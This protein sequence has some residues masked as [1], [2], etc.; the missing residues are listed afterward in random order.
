MA[1]YFS[2]CIPQFNRTSFLKQALLSFADQSFRDFEFCISDG[3]STDGRVD[4]LD[5]FLG[6]LGLPYRLA[7][8]DRNYRYDANLRRAIGLS[9]G[10]YLL[11]M[12]NDDAL[13]DRDCLQYLH[14]RLEAC[15]GAAVAITNFVELPDR[16]LFRRMTQTGSMGS[17]PAV[18][19]SVFRHHAFVSG[20]VFDG[21]KCREW[22]TD[23]VDGSE[24]Y[25]MY[26]GARLV[27]AGG[28]F[29]AIDRVAVDKDLQIENETVDSYRLRPR[30]SRWSLQERPLPMGRIIDT[31]MAG[32][33]DGAPGGDHRRVAFQVARQVYLFTYPFW[34]FEYRRVQSLA[35]AIGV[36]RALRPSLTCRT[37]PLR[38]RDR[39]ALWAIYLVL[40]AAALV[41]PLALFDAL[42]APLHRLAKRSR[43]GARQSGLEFECVKPQ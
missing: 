35:Y 9:S 6:E 7:R 26:L 36:Y 33:A 18:A 34:V 19:A 8:S 42:R 13:S 4:E 30:E 31:V 28:E 17:G 12:G 43:R 1:P 20:I 32:I 25:Q 5:R 10:R 21:P 40:G 14:D 3:G 27:A 16:T 11:L 41:V 39:P 24:M 2:V 15:P 38:R 22:A 37:V 23:R 29:L